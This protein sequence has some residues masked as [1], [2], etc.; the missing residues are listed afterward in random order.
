M[1]C[2]E[3][4]KPHKLFPLLREQ[5]TEFQEGIAI[6]IEIFLFAKKDNKNTGQRGRN[7]RAIHFNPQPP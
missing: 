5:E 3:T 2:N 6:V 1:P 7:H 4:L